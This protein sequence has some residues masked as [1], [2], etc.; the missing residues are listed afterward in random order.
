MGIISFVVFGL[1]VGF[2]GRLIAPGGDRKLGLWMTLAIGIAGSV[3]GGVV[4][5]SLGTGDYGEL[6]IIGS[7]VAFASA[8]VLVAVVTGASGSRRLGR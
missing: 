5:T 6:N 8:A 7:L 2:V 3:I 4:A 1:V